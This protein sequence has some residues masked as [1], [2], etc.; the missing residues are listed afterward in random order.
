MNAIYEAITV[1]M[2]ITYGSIQ[3]F[4]PTFSIIVVCNL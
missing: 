4:S 2:P 1:L 3:Y